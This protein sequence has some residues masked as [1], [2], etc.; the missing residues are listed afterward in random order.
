MPTSAAQR[1]PMQSLEM[2]RG[3]L[4]TYVLIGHARWLLWAGHAAW[5]ASQPP[6]WQYPFAY[7]SAAFRFGREAVLVFFALSGFFIHLASAGAAPGRAQFS[8][9]T[10]Y[11][12]RIHRLV[13]PYVFALVVTIIFD[14]L[15]RMRFPALYFAQTGDALLDATMRQTGYSA[16]SVLPAMLLLPSSAQFDFGTNGPL[17]S[18]A[19]EVV[20]YAVYPA[21]LWLRVRNAGAALVLVPLACL[22][23]GPYLPVAFPSSVVSLYPVWIAG[24]ALAEWVLRSKSNAVIR[25]VA[26]I[27]APCGLAVY[28]V[29][30]SSWVRVS[31]AVVFAVAVVYLFATMPFPRSSVATAGAYLGTR[32]FSIYIVHF[33][34]LV[35]MS[36]ACFQTFGARP[37]SGWLAVVGAASAIALA[38]AAFW[39]CERHFLHRRAAL[40]ESAAA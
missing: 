3:I 2:L 34:I 27:L 13:P 26:V 23:G 9:R 32:S 25:G 29:A 16:A 37:M 17:W 10:F 35:L 11:R 4:A 30:P 39:M 15:G 36:A 22:F 19:Y 8:A 21:W 38:C 20:Y 12:R 1:L 28:T 33:P 14:L 31:G 5:L 40:A 6:L 24:A 18:L 7:G